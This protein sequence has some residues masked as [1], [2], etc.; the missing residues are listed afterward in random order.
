MKTADV[1]E[2]FGNGAQAARFLGIT[3]G[4]IAMWPDVVPELRQYQLEVLT[5]GHF[6]ATKRPPRRKASK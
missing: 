5:R 3:R 2:Y 6:K 1:I 4:A